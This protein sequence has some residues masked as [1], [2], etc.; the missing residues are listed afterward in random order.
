[1][2]Y[3]GAYGDKKEVFDLLDLLC[4]WHKK[5]CGDDDDMVL[6]NS[7]RFEKIVPTKLDG[8]Y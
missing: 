6:Q 8:I 1:M 3:E 2:R 4:R 5:K 7:N